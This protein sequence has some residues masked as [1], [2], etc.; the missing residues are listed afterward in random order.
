MKY[1]NHL[2]FHFKPER[3]PLKYSELEFYSK[4]RY[5]PENSVENW[6][7]NL[8]CFVIFPFFQHCD[9]ATEIVTENCQLIAR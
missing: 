3:N 5:M 4:I 2:I 6:I 1:D 9:D 8:T 7:Q